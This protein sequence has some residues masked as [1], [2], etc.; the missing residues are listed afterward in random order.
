MTLTALNLTLTDSHILIRNY[1]IEKCH[2]KH[3]PLVIYS[4]CMYLHSIVQG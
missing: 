2:I 3:L 4:L 1:G